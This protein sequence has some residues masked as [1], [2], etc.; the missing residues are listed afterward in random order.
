MSS[1]S[2]HTSFHPLSGVSVGKKKGYSEILIR[3][4]V[5]ANECAG[6]LLETGAWGTFEMKGG[7][8][9]ITVIDPPAAAHEF[10]H[11]IETLYQLPAILNT[12]ERL[13]DTMRMICREHAK[14]EAGHNA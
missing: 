14:A 4:R 6:D 11:F 13:E 7:E 12:P 8:A 5:M 9:V 10:G 3:F 1:I 2:V